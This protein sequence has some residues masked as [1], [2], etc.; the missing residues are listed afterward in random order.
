MS[1]EFSFDILANKYIKN[2]ELSGNV[3][4][5]VKI[6]NKTIQKENFNNIFTFGDERRILLEKLKLYNWYIRHYKDCENTE[7]NAVKKCML[8]NQCFEEKTNTSSSS[9]HSPCKNIF[10]FLEDIEFLENNSQKKQKFESLIED[11]KT[12]IEKYKKT[13]GSK[14]KKRKTNKRKK[15]KTN[16]KKKTKSKTNKRKKKTRRR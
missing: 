2:L 8:I 13:G 1:Q 12:Y 5:S 15:T 3:I 10:E 6:D 9:E 16:K 14:S 4:E 7:N 11:V